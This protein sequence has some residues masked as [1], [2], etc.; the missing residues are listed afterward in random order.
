MINIGDKIKQLREL[1]GI[2]RKELAAEIGLSLSGYSK[3]ERGETDLPL[4]K[5][6]RISEVLEVEVSK[7]LDF[8]AQKV[9]NISNNQ[10]VQGIGTEE[11]HLHNHIS[12]HTEKYITMLETENA[13]L[14]G[15]LENLAR[16]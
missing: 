16:K 8:D 11:L 15:E 12:V 9:F 1:K 6:Y 2:S 14:K 5:L 7:I 13:R 10:T 3:L 4:S